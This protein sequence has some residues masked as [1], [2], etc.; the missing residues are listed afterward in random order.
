MQVATCGKPEERDEYM[1]LIQRFPLKPIRDDDEL[2]CATAMLDSLLD[3]DSLTVEAEEYLEVLEGLIEKYEREH[4]AIPPVPDHELLRHLIDAK[5][6]SQIEVARATGIVHTT[7]SA[8]LA[9]RRHLTREQIGK[10]SRYFG[11]SV[12]TFSFT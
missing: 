9:G 3:C 10:L 7:I 2:A 8:V 4:H 11:V 12:E 5:G 6:V 1:E